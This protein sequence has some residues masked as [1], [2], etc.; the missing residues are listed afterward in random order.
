MVRFL[1]SFDK[2]FDEPF[3]VQCCVHGRGRDQPSDFVK[4]FLTSQL[5][6]DVSGSVESLECQFGGGL[7]SGCLSGVFSLVSVICSYFGFTQAVH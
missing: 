7:V 5:P 2:P 3:H 4:K 6:H 1:R